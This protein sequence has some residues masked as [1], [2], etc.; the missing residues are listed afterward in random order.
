MIGHQR[1]LTV[2]SSILRFSAGA[3]LGAVL[4]LAAAGIV[5]SLTLEPAAAV[6]YDSFRL[7]GGTL[8]SGCS[9]WK[10]DNQL[11]RDRND[12][13]I[14]DPFSYWWSGHS[15]FWTNASAHVCWH[16]DEGTISGDSARPGADITAGA[17]TPIYFKTEHWNA[18]AGWPGVLFQSTGCLGVQ[19]VVYAPSGLYMSTVKYWPMSPASG[20]VGTNW[21]YHF[22]VPGYGAAYR[23]VGSGAYWDS[24]TNTD[25]YCT[26]YGYHLHQSAS[27]GF[28][29]NN[30]LAGSTANQNGDPTG[31][32]SFW[33][34]W[35]N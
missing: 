8:A 14:A 6:E 30:P 16:N 19:A 22:D 32:S 35:G 33:L 12:D 3:L 11:W 18:F 5:A 7:N 29:S 31:G 23:Q 26:T 24:Q 21:T 10:N 28:S 9:D 20:V 25:G 4:G 27:Q 17:S 1:T 15:R 34:R 13:G 2:V